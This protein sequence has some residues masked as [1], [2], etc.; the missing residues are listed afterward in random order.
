MFFFVFVYCHAKNYYIVKFVILLTKFDFFL[1]LALM[2]NDKCKGCMQFLLFL[3][4]LIFLILNFLY[5]V[6]DIL[7]P[8]IYLLQK[9]VVL[10][11]FILHFILIVYIREH[12]VNGVAYHAIMFMFVLSCGCFILWMTKSFT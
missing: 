2:S 9:I 3:M 7:F 4:M 5:E 1:S 8:V 6:Y 10:G 11:V 12:S